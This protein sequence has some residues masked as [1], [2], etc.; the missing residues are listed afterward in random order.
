MKNNYK[1]YIHKFPNDKVYVGITKFKPEYRWNNGYGYKRQDYVYRA[2][3]KYGW[4]NIKHEILESNLS[5]TEAKD[6]EKY[7]IA[8]YKSNDK[9]YGYNLTSGG[10]GTCNIIFSEER[11]KKIIEQNKNRV[12]SEETKEKLRQFNI[13]RHHTNETRL[14]MSEQ[15]KHQNNSFY[16][17]HHTDESKNKI[18]VSNSGF[19]SKKS[20][21]IAK[22]DFNYNLIEVYGS[23]RIA[24]KNGYKRRK[25]LNKIN[26][27]DFL[28]CGGFL[29]KILN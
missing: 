17:K 7:Y 1:V 26:D 25:C 14:K 16:G 20:I 13:G 10:D 12:V 22:Y 21:H 9:R 8:L 11:R 4:C 23:L 18:S 24:D 27:V 5:E 15:R 6:K 28:E 29:W 2:I 19:N 3:I